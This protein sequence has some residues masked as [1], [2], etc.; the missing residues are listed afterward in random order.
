MPA[1]AARL[2][3]GIFWN[4]DLQI[5][6]GFPTSIWLL[7]FP[8]TTTGLSQ[9]TYDNRT[10]REM[11]KGGLSKNQIVIVELAPLYGLTKVEDFDV[12]VFENLPEY[13]LFVKR[14]LAVYRVWKK[15][16]HPGSITIIINLNHN[17]IT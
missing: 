9:N 5:D 3:C 4:D 14:Q 10:V 13:P 2:K 11:I 7:A 8:P 1:I 16:A 6:K 12:N 17:H 15:Y